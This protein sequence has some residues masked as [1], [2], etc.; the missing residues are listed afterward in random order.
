[1]TDTTIAHTSSNVI[2]A[3]DR[4]RLFGPVAGLEFDWP[5]GEWAAT[6]MPSLRM[7]ALILQKNDRELQRRRRGRAGS[8]DGDGRADEPAHRGARQDAHRG[9]GAIGRSAG[10]DGALGAP[11]S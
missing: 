11:D 1:M 6:H 2:D 9:A 3:G 8:D 4:F 10:A 5:P 7:A